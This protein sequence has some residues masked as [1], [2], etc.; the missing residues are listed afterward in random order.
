MK[1]GSVAAVKV[2]NSS[3]DSLFDMTAKRAVSAAA[4]FPPLPEGFKEKELPILV[5]FRL[6]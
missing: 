4:P 2:K 3:G 6:Q 1:D 5:R